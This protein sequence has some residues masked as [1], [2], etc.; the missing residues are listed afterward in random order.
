MKRPILIILLA[1]TLGLGPA[2]A[3]TAADEARQSGHVVEIGL[4]ILHLAGETHCDGFLEIGERDAGSSR[5]DEP[6]KIS[7]LCA[8]TAM[9]ADLLIEWLTNIDGTGRLN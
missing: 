8:L 9:A 3:R 1:L 5:L 6:E 2:G 7:A 4:R